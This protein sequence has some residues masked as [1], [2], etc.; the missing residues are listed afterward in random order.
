[1]TKVLVTGASGFIAKHII[2]ELLE[3][4]Y[5]VKASVRSDNGRAQVAAL[6]PE[7][8]IEFVTLD[9]TSD[10]GW[11]A[12]MVGVDALLHTASPFPMGEPADPQ[13]LIRPAVDGTL[14]ALRAAQSAGV[15]R[16]VL[17]SSCAAIYKSSGKAPQAI[18][19]RNDWTDPEGPLTTAYEASKTLAERAAWDF[20]KAHPEMR[21][22]TVNPGAVLGAPL[23]DFYGTSLG[24]A[25]QIM[26]GQVPMFP[27][28]N[29]PLVDV[30]DVAKIHVLAIGNDEVIGERLPANAGAMYMVDM[31]KVAKE[32]LPARKIS[33]REAPNW[34]IKIMARFNAAL[35]P[36]AALLGLNSDV[37]GSD[38]PRELGFTYVPSPAAL[39]ASIEFLKARGK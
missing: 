16:V 34:L 32:A 8:D 10:E 21:L 36:T 5:Q 29:I 37:N 6:F 35:R 17:T 9:L 39:L 30:R 3:N 23:D 24:Y 19:T 20:V 28:V 25:E 18:S 26:A 31:A 38:A 22:T 11:D 33:D 15:T 2:R 4:D 7:A 27:H 13:E 14:R 1:M 12:A